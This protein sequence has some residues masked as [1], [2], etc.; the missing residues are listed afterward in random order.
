MHVAIDLTAVP[1]RLA[2]VGYYLVGLVEALQRIDADSEY[3][4]IVSDAIRSYFPVRSPR[5][6]HVV[7][8]RRSRPARLLWEQAVLPG[9]VTSVSADVLHSPHYT[10]PLRR[11]SCASVVGVMDLTY[12]LMPEH[13]MWPRRLFFRRMLPAAA[14]RADRVIAI[15]QS[16]KRDAQRLLGL[17]ADRIDAIPLA[18]DGRYRPDIDPSRVSAVRERLQLPGEYVLFVGTLEPRKNLPRL[19]RAYADVV[20]SEPAFPGLVLVGMRG[21]QTG[22]LERLLGT[23]GAARGITVAGYV[24]EDDLPAV[25]AGARMFVYP[26]LYEGF[27]IPILEALACGVPTITSTTSSMPEVAA[28]AALLVDPFDTAA[29]AGAMRRLHRDVALRESLRRKGP[30]RAAAF[31]WDETAR[32]TVGTYRRALADWTAARRE[33]VSA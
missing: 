18:A 24:P 22:E 29:L 14:A 6:S 16:T 5:F 11:L 32:M 7:V 1:E 28:D 17:P 23:G 3:R 2:G 20:S 19:L 21:W 25:Y 13:H 4:L 33:A 30:V 8:P 12:L 31:S 9:L 15:S 27:G 10:R 26:S